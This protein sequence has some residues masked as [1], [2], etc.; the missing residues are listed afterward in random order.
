MAMERNAMPVSEQ[1]LLN[2]INSVF[3]WIFIV[4][5]SSKLTAIGIKK[6]LDDRMNWLD[7]SVVMISIVEIVIMS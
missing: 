3:T 1:K 7:G 6:Y 4:E 2:E 5:L